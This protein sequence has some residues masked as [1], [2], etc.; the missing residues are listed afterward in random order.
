MISAARF[1]DGEHGDV[2]SGDRRHDRR[3]GEVRRGFF[4]NASSISSSRF[5][6]SS[7]RIRSW[8]GMSGGSGCPA[9]FFR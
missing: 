4:K 3:V 7:S 6:R 2:R 1:A 5:R 9:S 8:S